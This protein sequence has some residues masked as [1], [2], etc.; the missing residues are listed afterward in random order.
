MSELDTSFEEPEPQPGAGWT[1]EVVPGTLPD[2][3]AL[4]PHKYGENALF[5]QHL[6][7]LG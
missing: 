1:A 2:R 3:A 5:L 4:L 7:Q 6:R